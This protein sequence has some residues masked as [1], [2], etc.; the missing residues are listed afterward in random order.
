[1][2][3]KSSD[4]SYMLPPVIQG[5]SIF[6]VLFL[7]EDCLYGYRFSVARKANSKKNLGGL[8]LFLFQFTSTTHFKWRAGENLILMSGSHLY[9]PRNATVISKTEL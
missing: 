6:Y 3:G 7:D 1:M 9:F 2:T 8:C 5:T 4:P